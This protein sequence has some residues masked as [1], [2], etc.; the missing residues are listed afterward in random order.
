[1][2]SASGT[3]EFVYL[4][5]GVRAAGG[6]PMLMSKSSFE[7]PV[8]NT[9]SPG[10]SAMKSQALAAGLPVQL[11]PEQ[12]LVAAPLAS[13]DALTWVQSSPGAALN[14][15]HVTLACTPEPACEAAVVPSAARVTVYVF[16]NAPV[17]PPPP[18]FAIVVTVIRSAST[19]IVIGNGVGFV[20]TA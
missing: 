13:T 2:S 15:N 18:A 4:Q 17:H 1:M 11:A 6:V 3:D 10:G 8:V 16:L 7:P 5:L 9:V 12:G 19:W 20:V 14:V